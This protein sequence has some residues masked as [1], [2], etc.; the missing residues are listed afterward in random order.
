MNPEGDGDNDMSDSLK[1]GSSMSNINARSS[2]SEYSSNGGNDWDD[3]FRH[4]G[5]GNAF[6]APR[7]GQHQSSAKNNSSN[8]KASSRNNGDRYTSQQPQTSS[9]PSN[10]KHSSGNSK[11]QFQVLYTHQ[12]TK[13]KKQWKD[14]RLLLTGTRASLYEAC[15]LPGSSTA[16]IDSLDMTHAEA[17]RLV[18]TVS[19]GGV[20]EGELESEKY[21]IM[22]EGMWV[23]VASG[24]GG[25][26][27]AAAAGKNNH[28]LWNKQL[29]QS[30][31]DRQPSSSSAAASQGS[32]TTIHRG[33]KQPSLG[34]Q[35]LLSSK[36]R[37]PQKVIPLPPEEKRKRQWME[38]GV[39]K[40]KCRV[41]QPGELERRFY[42]GR[43]HDND[44]G[45]NERGGRYRDEDEGT[46]GSNA[47]YN[48]YD[49]RGGRGGYQ[50]NGGGP[51][52][53]YYDYN[54]PNNEQ[55]NYQ[56]TSIPSNDGQDNS[57]HHHRLPAS[58]KR[59]NASS[60]FGR[61]G[62]NARDCGDMRSAQGG[63]NNSN[64]C[65]RPERSG[66]SRFQS[67]GYDPSGFYAEEED[68]DE[69]DGDDEQQQQQHGEGNDVQLDWQNKYHQQEQGRYNGGEQSMDGGRSQL[70]NEMHQDNSN[71]HPNAQRMVRFQD[72]EN[73]NA[74]STVYEPPS[75]NQSNNT[76]SQGTSPHQNNNTAHTTSP[77][78]VRVDDELLA[79]LG[80]S[81][82]AAEESNNDAPVPFNCNG[83]DNDDGDDFNNNE[84]SHGNQSTNANEDPSNGDNSFL[85]SIRQRQ[86]EIE[87]SEL[88]TTGWS[89]STQS[90]Y[91]D[92]FGSN[93][94]YDNDEY[95]LDD[96]EEQLGNSNNG[97][98]GGIGTE[99][100]NDDANEYKHK[101][102][103]E[104]T[105]GLS[106]PSAGESSSEGEDEP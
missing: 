66:G 62:N 59:P 105:L 71:V 52:N 80:A 45:Y 24:G 28:P 7:G 39:N 13:K 97:G 55:D 47:I 83:S 102:S 77:E 69:H 21:L 34:M 27:A 96:D 88:R 100:R 106:L 14:G 78:D 26:G 51:N 81:P 38:N 22:V 16:A 61:F 82:S 29:P 17:T 84:Q 101:V 33:I 18:G 56:D 42:G 103:A 91:G 87:T 30:Q 86:T 40:R 64:Y 43:D 65:T 11:Q 37:M 99:M 79:L 1:N 93:C 3:S 31:H 104:H 53:N 57:S 46:D 63:G 94:Q 41:L 10:N 67:N 60:S 48:N 20:V 12:K 49:S 2:G 6:A 19:N 89:S 73:A 32:T 25:G 8:S 70:A 4:S 95:G 90:F 58:N 68:D 76:T 23:D 5:R 54:N 50:G 9:Y 35:K 15:P 44:N 75:N 85:A 36:F 98:E 92:D 72:Q 74:D